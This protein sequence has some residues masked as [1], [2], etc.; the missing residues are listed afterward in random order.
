MQPA[1]GRKFSFLQGEKIRKYLEPANSHAGMLHPTQDNFQQST[2]NWLNFQSYDPSKTFKTEY[3]YYF[4]HLVIITLKANSKNGFQ[5]LIH[6]SL[7][8]LSLTRMQMPLMNIDRSGLNQSM[9]MM[10]AGQPL[11]TPKNDR[12]NLS[13]I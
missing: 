3:Q 13:S 9:F 2:S 12:I 7:K 4:L 1:K 11:A 8:S 10:K 6:S 5:S